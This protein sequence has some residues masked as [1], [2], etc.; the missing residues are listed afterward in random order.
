M[1]RCRLGAGGALSR[2]C[3]GTSLQTM[4]LEVEVVCRPCHRVN[5]LDH[6]DYQKKTSPSSASFSSKILSLFQFLADDQ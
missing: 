3:R 5:H 4:S 1:I 2:L 6:C